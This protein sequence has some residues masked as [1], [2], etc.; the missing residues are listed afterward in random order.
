MPLSLINGISVIS[1]NRRIAQ[2]VAASF[3]GNINAGNSP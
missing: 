1:N 3:L 2:I